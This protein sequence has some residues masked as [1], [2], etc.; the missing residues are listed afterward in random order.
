MTDGIEQL[1]YSE[2]Y[3]YKSL[4]QVSPKLVLIVDPNIQAMSENTMNSISDPY[5]L[6]LYLRFVYTFH[7]VNNLSKTNLW[8]ILTLQCNFI[9]ENIM[10]KL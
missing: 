4:L 1:T 8:R 9:L 3:D 7:A 6:P 5:E 10:L 2:E